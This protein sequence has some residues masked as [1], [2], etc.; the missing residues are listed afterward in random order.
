MERVL[1][2]I[3]RGVLEF[4]GFDVLPPFV[5][6]APQQTSNHERAQ[7]LRRMRLAARAV[8]AQDV[9]TDLYA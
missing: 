7:A 9:G 1:Y 4:T 3:H 6:Y 2:P 5:V 8:A